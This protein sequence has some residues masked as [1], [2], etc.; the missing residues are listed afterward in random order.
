MLR[1]K[2]IL[3]SIS[4]DSHIWNLIY[5]QLVL[6]SLNF[7]VINMG[8]SVNVADLT[9]ACHRHQ[10]SYLVVSS[11]NGHGYLKGIEIIRTVKTMNLLKN[12]KVVIGGKLGVN[13]IITQ[14]QINHLYDEGYDEVF[15][16]DSAIEDFKNYMLQSRRVMK[17]V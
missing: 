5:L 2:V 11:V 17:A 10:P 7:D 8:P 6:E 16:K 1:Q 15:V 12:M 4:S 9:I 14:T 13:G 3:S